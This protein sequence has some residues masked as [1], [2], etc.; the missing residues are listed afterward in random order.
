VITPELFKTGR[1]QPRAPRPKSPHAA[2]IK[3]LMLKVYFALY[4]QRTGEK[5]DMSPRQW[6]M[7]RLLVDEHGP[8]IVERRLRLFMRTTDPWVVETA[9]FSLGV[10][11]SQWQKLAALDSPS[12]T[13]QTLGGSP[14]ATCRHQPPCPGGPHGAEHSRKMIEEMRGTRRPSTR[15]MPSAFSRATSMP[16][17]PF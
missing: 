3:R 5:P 11:R 7:L 8:E 10:F 1:K 9:G 13:T 4:A 14:Q 2:E 17:D 16:S 15:P 12:T 6:H